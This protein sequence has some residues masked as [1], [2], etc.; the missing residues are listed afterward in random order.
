MVYAYLSD[1]RQRVGLKGVYSA[2]KSVSSGVPQGSILGPLLF[3]LYINDLLD[4]VSLNTLM[5]LFADD[6]K[7]HRVIKSLADCLTL[8]NDIEA[9]AN[10]CT[11]WCMTLN[12]IKCQFISFNRNIN[13]IIFHYNIDGTVLAKVNEIRDLGVVVGDDLTFSSHINNIVKKANQTWATVR[14]VFDKKVNPRVMQPL[15]NSL[16]RS[17]LEYNTVSWDH[18]TKANLSKI[19]RVQRRATRHMIGSNFD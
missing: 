5:E 2:L 15:F 19:E 9:V 11:L 1:R 6:S 13:P 10:W 7:M 8:Q 12:V 4:F 17:K 3:Q 14:F 18:I 16:V